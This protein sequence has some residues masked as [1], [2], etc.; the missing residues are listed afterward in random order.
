ML[1]THFARRLVVITG[2]LGF[3]WPHLARQFTCRSSQPYQ[4]EIF[5]L[6]IDAIFTGI[7]IGLMG[8]NALPSAA[9]VMMMGMNMMGSGG[10]RL[11]LAGIAITTLSAVVTL[12][13]TGNVVVLFRIAGVVADAAGLDD[14]PILLPGEP[15]DGH[16][17][18][19]K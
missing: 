9:L 11:F 19:G 10:C 8:V 4:C 3:I 5:N 14:H 15:S 13:L 6:K 1:V 7:W 16:S 12:K 2:E 17:P 18:G